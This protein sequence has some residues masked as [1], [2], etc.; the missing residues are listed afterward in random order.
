M[1][2]EE[3]AWQKPELTLVVRLKHKESEF[4]VHTGCVLLGL[5]RWRGVSTIRAIRWPS[6]PGA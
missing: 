4:R 3:Q 6:P 1:T 2:A 5:I